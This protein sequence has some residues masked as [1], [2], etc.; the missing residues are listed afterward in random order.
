[1][2]AR[3]IARSASLWLRHAGVEQSELRHAIG[4]ELHDLDREHAAQRQAGQREFLGRHLVDDPACSAR[5]TVPD[6]KRGLAPVRH[7]DVGTACE[8]LR[9]GLQNRRGEH[10]TPGTSNK[11]VL[12]IS[13][14]QREA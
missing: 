14:L 1:M 6:G 9:P 2:R 3:R 10:S 7:D 4:G 11:G 8:R 12:V 13:F 5:P